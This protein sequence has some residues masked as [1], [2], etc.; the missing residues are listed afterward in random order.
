MDT[1]VGQAP[2]EAGGGFEAEHEPVLRPAN[3]A[4]ASALRTFAAK[5]GL[6]CQP[7]THAGEQP[8]AHFHPGHQPA[9]LAL[10]HHGEVQGLAW[11]CPA[12]TRP[13]PFGVLVLPEFR[14]AGGAG[15]LIRELAAEARR[16]GHSELSTCIAPGRPDP[17]RDLQAAGLRVVSAF[18]TGG[19]S[20]VRVALD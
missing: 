20:D 14:R 2:R 13:A 5:A 16:H 9:I 1:T 6:L 11:I 7:R 19:I 17:M 18:T 8:L 10:D 4:D 15:R 3:E 12:E